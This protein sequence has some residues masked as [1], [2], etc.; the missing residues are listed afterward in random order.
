MKILDLLIEEHKEIFDKPLEFDPLADASVIVEAHVTGFLT[1]GLTRDSGVLFDLRPSIYLNN[2]NTGL[3]IFR[4]VSQFAFNVPH[5]FPSPYVWYVGE[6]N[7]TPEKDFYRTKIDFDIRVESQLVEF[8]IGNIA[9]I[10]DE[11]ADFSDV[12]LGGF[13]AASPDWNMELD[14]IG[15]SCIPAKNGAASK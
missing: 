2:C 4:R 10:G 7:I 1:V 13:L 15:A 8:V 12:G 6:L 9:A 14:I 5:D 11:Q 3:L